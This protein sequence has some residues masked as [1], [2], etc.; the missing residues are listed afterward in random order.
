M[1]G[2]ESVL[3]LTCLLLRTLFFILCFYL[4]T[5]I[6]TGIDKKFY[7]AKFKVNF[8]VLTFSIL[9]SVL[10][11]IEICDYENS[12]IPFI[13]WYVVLWQFLVLE[14]LFSS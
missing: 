10:Q 9:K 12:E 14:I 8:K 7:F 6:L 1:I 2:N 5:Y 13:I 3:T 11:H 4:L